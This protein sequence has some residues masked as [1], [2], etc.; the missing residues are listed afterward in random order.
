LS[1]SKLINVIDSNILERDSCEKPVPT[2]SHRALAAQPVELSRDL[3][4]AEIPC[5]E[6]EFVT[7]KPALRHPRLAGPVA[8]LGDQ[9]LAPLIGNLRSG[10]TLIEIAQAWSQRMPFKSALSIALWLRHNGVLIDHA[11]ARP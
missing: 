11:E 9:P 1:Q 10:A 8:F 6:G 2:F 5:I 7:L 3:V 4:I